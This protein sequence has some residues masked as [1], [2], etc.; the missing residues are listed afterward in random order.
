MRSIA[1]LL[2]SVTIVAGSLIVGP[3]PVEAHC[4]YDDSIFG[5]RNECER[6][7]LRYFLEHGEFPMCPM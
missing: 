6:N 7:A 5:C 3:A 2:L 4:T 1:K